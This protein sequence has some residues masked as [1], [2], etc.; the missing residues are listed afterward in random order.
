MMSWIAAGRSG[1]QI[2]N[3]DQEGKAKIIILNAST[4]VYIER[5]QMTFYVSRS[6][7]TVWDI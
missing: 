7:A 6:T 1:I 3:E 4:Y 5:S 2:I